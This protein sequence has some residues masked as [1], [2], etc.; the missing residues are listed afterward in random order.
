MGH[1]RIY[2]SCQRILPGMSADAIA[3]RETNV[4]A[5]TIIEVC[6]TPIRQSRRQSEHANDRKRPA[7]PQNAVS[8]RI[9]LCG[10]I[11]L[12][13]VAEFSQ[14]RRR[15]HT[16]EEI[17]KHEQRSISMDRP[18]NYGMNQR[19]FRVMVHIKT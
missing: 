10:A 15:C 2:I 13:V 16:G 14:S 17:L 6:P 11:R 5:V 18:L 9:H 19:G 1:V 3:R 12:H 4:I 8:F 7:K